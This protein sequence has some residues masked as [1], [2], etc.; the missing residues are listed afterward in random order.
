MSED[1]TRFLTQIKELGERRIEE[2]EA[3]SRELEQ[4]ILQDRKE[5]QA[6]RRERA[7]S[8]SPL[9][10][11]PAHTPSPSTHTPDSHRL[12]RLD[13]VA[14]PVLVPPSIEPPPNVGDDDMASATSSLLNSP[15]KRNESPPDAEAEPS[16]PSSPTRNGP[17]T[18]GLSWQRRPN[19]QTPERSRTRPLSMVAA[20]N[21]ARSS[22]PYLEQES[23]ASESFSKDQIASASSS[24]ETSWFR[25]TADRGASS[26]AY[27]RSQVE[28]TQT[29]DP[30]SPQIQLSGMSRHVSDES[31]ENAETDTPLPELSEP[32]SAVA[33]PANLLSG[34]RLDPPAYIQS[35]VDSSQ[36]TRGPLSRTSPT[37]AERPV[38]PTKGV[39]GFV[40]SAML[41]RTE[42]VNKR[43]SVQ[44]PIT[45]HRT[46]PIASI[47]QSYDSTNRTSA[48]ATIRPTSVL[49][50]ASTEPARPDSGDDKEEDR[51]QPNAAALLGGDMET[52]MP[53]ESPGLDLDSVT[54]P[55]SPSKT[56]DPRRWSPQKS[57]WLESALNKPESPK[58]KPAQ[59]PS[60]QPAWMAELQRAKAQ[61]AANPG[62]ES[63]NK[64]PVVSHKHQV[65]IGGLM[66]SSAPGI[67]TTVKNAPFHGHSHS[68][69]AV[70][71]YTP[72]ANPEESKPPAVPN[73]AKSKPDSAGDGQSTGS[74]PSVNMLKPATPP[75][76]DFRAGLKPSIPTVTDSSASSSQKEEFKNIFGNLRRTATQNYVAPDEFRNNITRGKAALAVTG[77]PQKSERV[78]EFKEAILAK[79]K[80]FQA[81]NPDGWKAPTKSNSSSEQLV[82]ESILKRT[83]LGRSNT[84]KRDP[85]SSTTPRPD[86]RRRS[87]ISPGSSTAAS[88]AERLQRFNNLEKRD[89]TTGASNPKLEDQG[90][91]SEVPIIPSTSISRP[92]GTSI[93]R[94]R[95]TSPPRLPRL[96][97]MSTDRVNE[98][99]RPSRPVSMFVDRVGEINGPFRSSRPASMLAD[100]FS[101]S[102]SPPR[103]SRPVSMSADRV[104]ETDDPRAPGKISGNALASRFNPALGN[105]LARGPPTAS[106][107][108]VNAGNFSSVV[109]ADG[110]ENESG[111][112]PKLTHMTKNRARGPRR[113]APTI[114]SASST[115]EKDP[116]P[117]P[118]ELPLELDP[119]ARQNIQAASFRL[120]K[121]SLSDSSK[122]TPVP[123]KPRP[124]PISLVGTS[125]LVTEFSN[126]VE[127]PTSPLKS[128][129]RIYEQVAAFAAQGRQSI[130]K[131]MA[132]EPQQATPSSPS[133]GKLNM[134]R[135]S[136]FIDIAPADK[137]SGEEQS[138]KFEM[139]LK[140]R[141]TTDKTF[142]HEVQAKSQPSS[143]SWIKPKSPSPT[144]LTPKYQ[145]ST[146][147]ARS[148]ATEFETKATTP[149]ATRLT[150]RS[151]AASESFSF[152]PR[153]LPE[154]PVRIHP[155]EPKSSNANVS[156]LP[157][158]T[159]QS[160]DSSAVLQDFFGSDRPKRKYS[161]DV[162]E[163]LMQH[164]NVAPSKVRTS[165]AQLFLISGGRKQVVPAH[166]ERTLFEREVYLCTHSFKNEAGKT[167]VEVY[168]WT[169]D[170]VSEATIESTAVLAAHEARSYGGTLIKLRQGKE[171]PGFLQALGGIVII[172]RGS[173]H[174]YDSLAPRMLC[175]R[176]YLGHV[177]FDEVDFTPAVLCSGFP[178]LL[179]QAGRCY[180]WKGKGSSIDELGCARLIGTDCALSGEMEEVDEGFE[181]VTFWDLFDGAGRIGSADHWRLKPNY[182]KYRSRLFLSDAASKQQIVELS[183]FSQADLLPTNIYVIDAFFELYIVVGARA[184]AQYASFHNALDFAQ[185]YAILAAGMEDRPFVPVSTVVLEGIPRDMK[186]VFRKWQ[187]SRSPTITNVNTGLKRGRS[188]KI[189]PLSK[190]LQALNK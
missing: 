26:A 76:K 117:S 146:P 109:R 145:P 61:K 32:S 94:S 190:A 127:V 125:K 57:S 6:R 41:K 131:K 1:V 16:Y 157:S 97:S 5:R 74:L 115:A 185:E 114:T 156:P 129:S 29:V 48:N 133:P 167:I 143:P 22:N 51:P 106:S 183:M 188:L 100:R 8:I 25:Q 82:P 19:S 158:P 122:D 56:M 11:S 87:T 189:V 40:Q 50:G 175:G 34:P 55:I 174:M 123:A 21:A 46:D 101:E 14:S 88:L 75:K 70:S 187:D 39:G 170:G 27:R 154:A 160:P 110:T 83:E 77:G 165:S 15:S 139:P 102:N 148:F 13:L 45:L 2:D 64:P 60:N 181:P 43:W 171:T 31:P 89:S 38:S 36:E 69:S 149:S 80:E 37:K 30:F 141:H 134:N 81:A 111:S 90:A 120:E 177:V 163:L 161:V 142:T 178:Y 153:P 79:K 182:D 108:G 42:S 12:E 130:V 172:Q 168:F 53:P 180:L 124:R 17:V 135:I 121:K 169:G 112:G 140:L 59:P 9:K 184:Q 186:S 176:H 96:G 105:L 99:S 4:K 18:R 63:N 65:S 98:I 72:H 73:L 47:R 116:G 84:I 68:F 159:K 93:G 58:P 23:T 35:D 78:D 107:S 136:R 152:P 24:K 118:S 104:N 166:H 138:K 119:G 92:A 155:Q 44:S 128:G 3:R 151:S 95:E 49:R 113:K 173:A 179:T 20:E 126:P 103:L 150:P 7:R 66:R 85:V 54:P 33:S 137:G 62:I 28:D 144:P 67:N 10:S 52:L 86:A 91:K 71:V 132:D 147:E 162:A 164:S